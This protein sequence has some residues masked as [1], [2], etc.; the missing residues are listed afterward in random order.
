MKNNSMIYITGDL[1][2]PI[3]ISKLNTHNFPEQKTLT[4]SDYVIICGDA[5]IVWD[6]GKEDQYWQ[7]WLETRNFTT[8]FVDGNHENFDMLDNMPTK[9]WNGGLVHEVQPSVLHLMRGHVFEIGGVK[10]FAMGGAASHDRW[11]R[12]IRVSW[13]PQEEITTQDMR[14]AMVNLDRHSWNV[15]IVISHC[16]PATIEK[17]LSSW[18]DATNSSYFLEDLRHQVEFKKWYFGHYHIDLKMDEH[19]VALYNSVIPI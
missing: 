18:Y 11:N 10:L 16:A 3:D 8:L 9:E 4:K 6:G 14:T 19:Y 17:K 1:H 15:D 12:K 5:G 13:W 2:C 7:N